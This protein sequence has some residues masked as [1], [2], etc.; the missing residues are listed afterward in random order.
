MTV[1]HLPQPA[2]VLPQD[3]QIALR[4]AVAHRFD[5]NGCWMQS[6]L[7]D[8]KP[9]IARIDRIVADARKRYPK[10]FRTD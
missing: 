8:Q 4:M 1:T 6:P 3:I 10:K 2:N 7:D 9:G 5:A